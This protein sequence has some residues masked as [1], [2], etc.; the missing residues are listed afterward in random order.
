MLWFLARLYVK[1]LPAGIKMPTPE[2]LLLEQ[3]IFRA[4]FLEPAVREVLF[5][6][7]AGYTAWYPT[8]FRLRPG[9]RFATID[10]DPR[11]ASYGARGNHRVAR[12]QS[13]VDA[14]DEHARFDVVFLS[15]V[16]G[17]GTDA[18]ADQ[19]AAIDA[20]YAVLRPGGRLLVGYADSHGRD[21]VDLTI[22]DSI[23]WSPTEVP[24]LGGLAHTVQWKM[25]H[26]FVCYRK[27]EQTPA[28]A[29]A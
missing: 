20:A 10:S 25:R 3:M 17:Y 9:L 29:V 27:R 24:G 4:L 12:F 13:L 26:T 11:A 28:P 6:G 1:V 23:R 16:F 15:S 7:V 5:V 18:E 19:R 14:E 2:R 21:D 8:I 22:I